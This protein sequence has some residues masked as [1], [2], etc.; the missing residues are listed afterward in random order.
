MIRAIIFFILF[1]NLSFSQVFNLNQKPIENYL[2]DL[3]L[4]ENT[5]NYSFSIKANNLN[6]SL[7]KLIYK[8]YKLKDKFLNIS[9]LPIDVVS[10]YS[11]DHPYNHNNGIMI[12]N[13]GIQTLTSFGF[14]FNIGLIDLI[15]KPE[16]LIAENLEFEGFWDG[17]YYEII[18]KRL[19]TWN[20]ID[21]PERFGD[22]SYK[23]FSIGQ[24]S[25]NFNFKP[26]SI[27]LSNE[28]LWW[29]PA[30]R[31]SIMLSNNA[32]SFPHISIKSIEPIKLL[33][34][35][36]NFQIISG[37]LIGS[38]F[39][40]SY[41]N[42]IYASN[43]TY[44]PKYPEKRYLQAIN[45]N[46]NPNFINGL[47]L[48]FIRWSQAYN[49][50]VKN[51]NDYFPIFDN[52]LRK[53][54]K[55]GVQGGSKENE[56][57]QAAGIYLRWLWP[58]S[59]AEFYAEFY[60]NDS[61]ANFRDLLL[62]SDH[63]RAS[64]IGLQK[65]FLKKDTS[66]YYKFS[67]EWTQLEQTS[68]RILREAGSWYVHGKVRHGYTNRGEV[69]GASIGPG[70]NSH[71]FGIDRVI[72]NLN[73]GAYIEII[74]HDNDFLYYAFENARDFRRYWKDYNLNLKVTIKNNRNWLSLYGTY[75]RAINYQ[76]GL[77]ENFG[78]GYDYY[79]PGIDK[80]NLFIKLIFTHILGH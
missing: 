6:D 15:I 34:G 46:Y 32:R 16:F 76:W 30:R 68:S 67:W 57:D 2:R 77:N 54:D 21:S 72:N 63:A 1:V 56:R 29:G 53:N 64:T 51:N 38:G 79:I 49:D 36:I 13:K 55:Y 62:D 31:N 39:K 24:S 7:N 60:Y 41:S 37:E 75:T 58:K 9:L 3:Q 4:I 45:F 8:N 61:K 47:T 52:L 28:N 27:S 80:N 42:F 22:K 59:N 23:E 50:F 71:N 78:T 12:P 73:F 69:I 74:D 65:I 44:V 19:N 5:F 14:K 11:S 18:N 26:V 43:P 25:I 70:S 48:G 66:N 20:H 35:S 40:P 10:E 33:L 17:H